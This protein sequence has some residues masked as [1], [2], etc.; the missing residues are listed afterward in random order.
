MC[1]YLFLFIGGICKIIDIGVII[2]D[3]YI[4]FYMIVLIFFYIIFWCEFWFIF[5]FIDIKLILK[6]YLGEDCFEQGFFFILDWWIICLEMVC[7]VV[8]YV[9]FSLGKYN[10][11]GQYFVMCMMWYMFVLVIKKYSQSVIFR[12][13]CFWFWKIYY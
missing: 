2:W 7:N 1:F 9:L 3:V 13:I 4:L 10:C 11:I 6:C 12:E 8:V 5:Y